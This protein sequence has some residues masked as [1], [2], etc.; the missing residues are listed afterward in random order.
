MY[1]FAD[2]VNFI[3]MLHFFL[4][5]GNLLLC[6]CIKYYHQILHYFHRILSLPRN[7]APCRSN[8]VENPNI[9]NGQFVVSVLRLMFIKP[10]SWPTIH[11]T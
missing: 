10:E 4:S 1:I 5:L 7:L 2:Q 11:N 6:D 8:V 3:S 9:S